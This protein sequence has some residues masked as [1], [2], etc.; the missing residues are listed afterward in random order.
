MKTR[1]LKKVRKRFQILEITKVN[2]IS[3]WHYSSTSEYPY[4][5]VIDNENTFATT[6]NLNFDDA[7]NY[8]MYIIRKNYFQYSKK[9]RTEYKKVWYNEK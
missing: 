3:I 9:S 4:Y 5:I 7:I 6:K 2:D 1:L 8:L